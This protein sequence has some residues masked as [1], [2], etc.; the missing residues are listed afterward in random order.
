MAQAAGSNVIDGDLKGLLDKLAKGARILDMQG[1]SD[2][3]FGHVTVRDP[4]GRGFWMKRHQISLGEVYDDRDF[5]LVDF[6]GNKLH[7]EGRRHSEWPIHGEILRRRP[8]INA[9]GH[10]HPFYS[11]IYSAMPDPLVSLRGVINDPPPRFEATSELIVTKE[12]GGAL[13][14]AMG[15]ANSMFMRNHGVVFCGESIEQMVRNGIELESLSHQLLVAAGSGMPYSVP[16]AAEAERAR[17]SA[18]GLGTDSGL[19]DYYCRV[20]ARAERQGMPTLATEPVPI[21]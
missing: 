3:I 10:T 4:A 9:V 13:A 8:E 18:S 2:R 11:T 5:V 17:V 20:L 15:Q 6:D 7:G 1:H 19:W 12:L 14:E 21:Q 16:S